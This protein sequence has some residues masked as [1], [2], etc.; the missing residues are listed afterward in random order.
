MSDHKLVLHYKDGTL[1]AVRSQLFED[2]TAT[3]PAVT[4]DGEKLA[5]PVERLKAAFFV[6]SYLGNPD[7]QRVKDEEALRAETSGRFVRIRFK[8]GETLLGEVS[9]KADLGRPFFLKLLDPNDNNL[10]VYVNPKYLDGPP[11]A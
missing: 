8:D 5:V 9:S 4:Q 11:E 10:M 6:K 3:I 1:H 7:Y 2:G